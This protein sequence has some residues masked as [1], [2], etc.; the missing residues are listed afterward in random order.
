MEND[1]SEGGNQTID[2]FRSGYR[3]VFHI[4]ATFL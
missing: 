4:L 2:E 1:K 3:G